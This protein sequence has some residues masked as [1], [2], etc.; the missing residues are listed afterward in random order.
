MGYLSVYDTLLNSITVEVNGITYKARPDP[1]DNPTETDFPGF[2]LDIPD[3]GIRE[4]Y[5]LKRINPSMTRMDVVLI[6]AIHLRNMPDSETSLSRYVLAKTDEITQ[7]MEDHARN[8]TWADDG[9]TGFSAYIDN[10]RWGREGSVR[11]ARFN[12]RVEAHDK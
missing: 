2:W 7:M 10:I 11:A 1:P 9:A 5:D 8:G 3:E 6:L 12:I 4:S